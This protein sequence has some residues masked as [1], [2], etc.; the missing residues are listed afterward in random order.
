VRAIENP[1]ISDPDPSQ[2]GE[3]IEPVVGDPAA[4]EIELAQA[5]ELV[6]IVPLAW[7]VL[8]PAV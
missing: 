2:P 4:V 7:S 5:C 3:L 1:V 6:F 8:L